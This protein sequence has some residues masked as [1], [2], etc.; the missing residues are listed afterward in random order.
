MHYTLY[1][2][3]I[4]TTQKRESQSAGLFSLLYIFKIQYPIHYYCNTSV[5]I[6]DEV[7][8]QF[9]EIAFIINAINGYVGFLSIYSFYVYSS[10][11]VYC[12]T[13]FFVVVRAEG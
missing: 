13:F 10:V 12:K 8:I 5:Y 9:I 7:L 6:F 3:G 11:R 1:I 2:I 4:Y